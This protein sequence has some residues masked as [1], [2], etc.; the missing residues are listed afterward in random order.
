ME[1]KHIYKSDLPYPEISC[2][3]KNKSYANLIQVNYAG[4]ISELTAINQYI[5]HSLAVSEKFKDVA[6]CLKH[7]AMVEM[8]HLEILGKLIIALGG[9]PRFEINKGGRDLE[10]S[11]KFIEYGSNLASMLRENIDGEKASIRQYKSTISL[12]KDD[13]IIKILERIIVDG[14][15]HIKT[16]VLLYNEVCR[17]R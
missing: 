2:Q 8:E 17:R 11:P 1:A 5:Y 7:I 9:D 16:L 6:H 3:D 12:I 15:I 4:A 10:W 13:K 14:E